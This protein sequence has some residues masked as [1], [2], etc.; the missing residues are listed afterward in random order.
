MTDAVSLDEAKVFLRVSHTAEDEL[1][2]MLIAAAQTKLAGETGMVMDENAPA[3]LRLCALYLIAQAY[4]G[5]GE[6]GFDPAALE[7][8][9]APYREARL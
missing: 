7:P 8:W 5:R 4:D 2:A 9:I 6:T 3:D 1:I